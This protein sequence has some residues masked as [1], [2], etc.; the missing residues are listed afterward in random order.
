MR[1]LLDTV[2]FLWLALEPA[3]LS[4]RA[5]API[6]DPDNDLYLSAMSA[7][8]IAVKFDLG[9]LPLPSFLATFVPS[10]RDSRDIA[11]LA[12]SERAALAVS[13]LPALHRDPFDRLLIGQ[14]AIA[15][16]PIRVAW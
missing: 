10:E 5:I 12:M 13:K 1:L 15:Q 11:S 6:E 7:Y 16:Y 4:E 3:R 8:E 2:A 9:K 14:A